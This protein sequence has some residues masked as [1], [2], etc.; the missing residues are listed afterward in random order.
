MPSG[1]SESRT[2]DALLTTTLANYREKLIDNI[3][4]VYPF[5]SYLNGKLG[6]AIRGDTVKRTVDGGESIVEHLLYGTNDTV[7][8]YSGAEQLDT[9]LQEG[10]TIARYN[11]KQYAVSVG[12]TGLEKRNNQGEAQMINLLSAKT[13]QAEQSLRD[14]MSRNAF[15]DGTGNSSK[16]MLGLQALVS[17][18]STLAGIA[19]GTYS[20]WAATSTTGG[21]FAAQGIDDMRTTFNTISYG[22]DKP[23]SIF[24]T[25]TVFEYYEK[26]LQPQERYVNTASGDA[27]FQ[28]LTFKGVP[29][30]FDR[31]CASGK[32]Y[33]LNSKYLSFVVHRDADMS[34]GPFV[35]P[36]NQDVSTAMIL[37]QGN[38]T[39]NNRRMLGE[40]TAITA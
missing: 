16:D 21:S 22:N 23:D 24:T 13:M 29:M 10:M 28:N 27:G 7:K 2:W 9:T 6:K 39:T 15:G 26:A 38:L 4:D 17:S 8:S 34:T 19:P 3:F 33:F 1:V 36:E 35:T 30:F 25:Q 20:W 5:L 18:S 14:R 32:M 12:I 31:D 37:W 40:V 11:W